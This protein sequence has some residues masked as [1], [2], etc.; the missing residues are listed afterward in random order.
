MFYHILYSLSEVFTPL[1]V[2]QY[3]TFRAG[4]AI[5]T[6]LIITFLIAPYI[7]RT[8]KKYKI[9]QTV[10]DDGPST[11]KLK[12]G[13]T[14]M[15]GIIIIISLLI[16]TLLWARLDNIF[17]IW[18][19]LATVFFGFIGFAD[20]YLKLIKKNP[21]GLSARKKLVFQSIFAIFVIVY[22]FFYPTNIQFATIIDIPYLKDIF[23]EMSYFYFIIVFFV[24]V[25]SSN[26]VNL[27]DGQDGLAIG[28][29]I[30]VA[31]A[32]ALFAYL[33]GN[34]NI[35]TYLKVPYINGAGEISVFLMA[36]FGAG[37][38]FLWYNSYP[39][40]IFMGD[41]GSLCLGAVL[42]LSAVFI[43]QELILVIL[44]GVFVAEA[45]SVMIQ[46]S[47]FKRT[48]K[49]FFKMAPLHHHFELGGIS[50]IKVTIRFW[51]VGIV[52]AILAV[53]SLKLR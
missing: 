34:V 46:V 10:R 18:L 39:A 38:G 29:I 52:L 28:N 19:I 35:A 1:N 14:T 42:G 33:I 2:F 25:G 21:K 48:K 26:A 5:L 36:L 44:G 23:I 11:H 8:L 53:S 41:T 13:T 16:S 24:I 32:L 4:G 7:I 22:L 27:T 51:I 47:V 45:L 31:M 49:R 15:G 30:I 37:L 17:I 40:E 50:E 9:S 3:I 43:K 12:S 20:D 6:S